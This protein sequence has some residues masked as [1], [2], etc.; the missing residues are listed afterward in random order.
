MPPRSRSAEQRSSPSRPTAPGSSSRRATSAG[1]RRGRPTSTSSSRRSTAQTEPRKLTTN[2]AW[3]TQPVFSPDGKQLAY[4]AMARP[5]FEADRFVLVVR[6]GMDGAERVLT[7]GWDRSPEGSSGRRTAGRSTSR[8][9]MSASSALRDR[10]DERRRRTLV[11]AGRTARSASPPAAASSSPRTTSSPT[12]LYGEG[13]RHRREAD[14]A[15]STP[16]A[17]RP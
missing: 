3:D 17:S 15:R 8:P 10:R 11:G 1:K 5:G 7:Q 14:H 13:R 12:E 2:P 4:L 6:D 9:R 16:S